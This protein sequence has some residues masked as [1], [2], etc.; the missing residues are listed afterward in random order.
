MSNFKKK[1]KDVDFSANYVIRDGVSCQ[2]F[3]LSRPLAVVF[4]VFATVNKRIHSFIHCHQV[5]TPSLSAMSMTEM[6]LVTTRASPAAGQDDL[7]SYVDNREREAAATG[8]VDGLQ[9]R[10]SP[11]QLG[12]T[13]ADSAAAVTSSTPATVSTAISSGDNSVF[14]MFSA[15]AA[16][17]QH[18]A[19]QSL[20]YLFS[21]LCSRAERTPIIII[22]IIIRN[23]KIV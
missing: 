19:S 2:I 22:I 5:S 12:P 17:Q 21:P 23:L 14:S 20:T 4:I 3:C 8:K 1:L 15:S 16:H 10:F 11:P 9:V 18:F 13:P 6:E 7:Q